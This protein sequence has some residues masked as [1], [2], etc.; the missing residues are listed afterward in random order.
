[1]NLEDLRGTKTADSVDLV[2]NADQET[3]YYD[4]SN[5]SFACNLIN[6]CYGYLDWR[7]TYYVCTDKYVLDNYHDDVQESIAVCKY[8]FLPS[9]EGRFTGD[10]IIPIIVK[11]EDTGDLPATEGMYGHGTTLFIALQIAQLMG[12]EQVTFRN[13]DLYF[14]KKL[15]FYG[16]DIMA[17]LSAQELSRRRLRSIQAHFWMIVFANKHKMRLNYL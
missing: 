3:W 17:K 6:R 1:M 11:G 7:P 4:V 12:F 9:E 13:C 10:N 15:H 16:D 14:G 8:A 2:G 5:P